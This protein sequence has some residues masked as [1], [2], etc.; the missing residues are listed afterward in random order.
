MCDIKSYDLLAHSFGGR[1]ALRLA[2]IDDR[3]DKLI[4]TG[5]A[6][7]KPRRKISYY[8]KVYSYKILKKILPQKLLKN[9]GSS[10]Y[11]S[12][13]EI[14][15]QSYKKIVNTYQD[16]EL[17]TI[18]NKTLIVFGKNDKSTPL[19]MAK[20]LNQKIK[21][22]NLIIIE[23]AGHFAFTEKPLL[24]NVYLKEFLLGD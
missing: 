2:N 23:D 6:G 15:R 13:D 12:L 1:I 7:L 18:K 8:I 16:G 14:M 9:F 10:E 17:D 24:F 11:K 19:F 5:C 22:S 21:N 4:L 20:K 3:L